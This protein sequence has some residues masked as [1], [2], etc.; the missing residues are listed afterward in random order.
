[1][2]VSP[3]LQTV[4]W[5]RSYFENESILKQLK[6]YIFW[7]YVLQLSSNAWEPSTGIKGANVISVTFQ[8]VSECSS[9][10]LAEFSMIESSLRKFKINNNVNGLGERGDEMEFF[11]FITVAQNQ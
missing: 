3:Y 2:T 11:A 4:I 6:K 10:R 5:L 9:F 7:I 1:M 8:K